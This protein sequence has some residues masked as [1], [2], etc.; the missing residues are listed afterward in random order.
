MHQTFKNKFE[1]W[2]LK[3]RKF[4]KPDSLSAWNLGS[5]KLVSGAYAI[6]RIDYYL[7]L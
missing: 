3:D 1:I 6:L 4:L 5:V 2:N 7:W